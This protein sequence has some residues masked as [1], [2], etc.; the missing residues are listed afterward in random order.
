[1]ESGIPYVSHPVSP[2][3]ARAKKRYLEQRFG[4][5]C[6]TTL[7]I[8][9]DRKDGTSVRMQTPPL[10]WESNRFH[11]DQDDRIKIDRRKR[12]PLHEINPGIDV[13][14]SDENQI[15]PS[16]PR[17]ASA[18]TNQGELRER[19]DEQ[20]RTDVDFNNSMER[21]YRSCEDSN[22][23]S[24]ANEISAIHVATENLQVNLVKI[25]GNRKSEF[26][27]ASSDALDKKKLSSPATSQNPMEPGQSKRSSSGK[28]LIRQNYCKQAS[29]SVIQTHSI[30]Q[31]DV[32]QQPSNYIG[33]KIRS[34]SL[35]RMGRTVTSDHKGQQ[36]TRMHL[37][38]GFSFMARRSTSQRTTSKVQ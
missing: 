3:L 22:T 15:S 30:Y 25:H 5:G 24:G 31:Q 21:T 23:Y 33:L 7:A 38:K 37:G 8:C 26:M 29:D 12:N 14:G 11:S 1:M 2:E 4:N 27:Q 13:A 18:K 34:Q 16:F 19:I 17:L 6:Q 36:Q 20:F 35:D 28:F 32:H 10:P 9:D